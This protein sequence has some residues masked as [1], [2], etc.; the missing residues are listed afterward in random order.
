[1]NDPPLTLDLSPFHF[2]LSSYSSGIRPKNFSRDLA[3]NYSTFFLG[4]NKVEIIDRHQFPSITDY[5]LDKANRSGMYTY[6][7]KVVIGAD[8]QPIKDGLRVTAWYSG[9]PYHAQPVSVVYLV[10]ALLRQV[11]FPRI[12]LTA[13]R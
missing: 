7:W 3:G 4:D 11:C 2:S 9:Q 12:S 6:N 1:M 5:Y 8:F 10:N 13:I